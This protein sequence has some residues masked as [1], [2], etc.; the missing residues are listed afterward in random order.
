M[1]QADE[2]LHPVYECFARLYDELSIDP[3]NPQSPD[4]SVLSD[5]YHRYHAA[6]SFALQE[7]IEAV[8]FHFFVTTGTLI[9]L[10]HIQQLVHNETGRPFQLQPAD[11]LLG[12]LDLPGE[13]MRYATNNHSLYPQLLGCCYGVMQG[14]DRMV[15]GLVLQPYG[16]YSGKLTVM[17]ESIQ[18]LEKLEYKQAVREHVDEEVMAELVRGWGGGLERKR[19]LDDDD[20]VG[21]GARGTDESEGG[22]RM[23]LEEGDV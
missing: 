11:Y 22:K 5:S 23:R 4:S 19:G 1:Q 3:A 21:R 10:P 6:Y 13:M 18:K 7:Y 8:S 12:L 2:A 14:L 20:G 17:R 15:S 9:T 16:V